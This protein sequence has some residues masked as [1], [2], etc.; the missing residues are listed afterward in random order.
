MANSC[1]VARLD[2]AASELLGGLENLPEQVR[3]DILDWMY[4]G[5]LHGPA[6]FCRSVAVC[7][8]YPLTSSRVDVSGPVAEPAHWAPPE[9]P[10]R[11]G[12]VR[13]LSRPVGAILVVGQAGSRST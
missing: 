3:M 4:F 9:F 5:I 8:T 13:T 11:L 12:Q 7:P 2:G 1:T 10:T 6:I